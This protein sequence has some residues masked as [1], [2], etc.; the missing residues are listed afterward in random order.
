MT[1]PMRQ[2]NKFNVTKPIPTITGI[3]KLAEIQNSSK[4]VGSIVNQFDTIGNIIAPL[5]SNL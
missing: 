1:N 2:F 5:Q 4:G 3:E